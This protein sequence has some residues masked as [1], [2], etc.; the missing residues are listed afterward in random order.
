MKRS[1]FLKTPFI[2]LAIFAGIFFFNVNCVIALSNSNLNGQYINGTGTFQLLA[3]NDPDDDFF[4]TDN[5]TYNV[6][7]DGTFTAGGGGGD[8]QGLI[9]MEPV[10]FNSWH[11]MTL[12]MIF[13]EPTTLH[14]MLPQ[15]EHSQQVVSATQS[16]VLSVQMEH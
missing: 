9:Q 7:S 10:R 11:P 6:A 16:M 2:L 8:I 4:G 15:T 13:S 3:S 12:M 5:F 14:T 1:L